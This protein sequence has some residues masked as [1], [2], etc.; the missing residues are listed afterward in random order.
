MGVGGGGE[1]VKSNICEY[2]GSGEGGAHKL[3]D[4]TFTGQLTVVTAIKYSA[5]FISI[6]C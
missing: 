1:G 3:G 2:A 5:C 6:S 4:L